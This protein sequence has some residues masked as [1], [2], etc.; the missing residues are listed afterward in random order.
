VYVSFD[1][2]G[3]WDRVGSNMPYFPVYDIDYNPV[4]NK[5]IAASFA[6]GIM[7]F[8]VEELELETSIK[9]QPES[10]TNSIKVYPTISTGEFYINI[11]DDIVDAWPMAVEVMDISGKIV[12]SI[13][14]QNAAHE[15]IELTSHPFPGLYF[16]S[17]QSGLSSVVRQIVIK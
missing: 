3:Q 4:G 14:L 6:R 5:I 1:A 17:I 2:G 13:K 12:E 10:L 11:S 8:P 15:K 16:I 9:N 7:T